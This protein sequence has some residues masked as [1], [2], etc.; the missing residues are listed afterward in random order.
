MR[1][2]GAGWPS[3]QQT[4]NRRSQARAADLISVAGHS[5]WAAPH[6]YCGSMSLE[7]NSPLR[8]RYPRAPRP[9]NSSV[10][11]SR[12]RQYSGL[13]P[14]TRLVRACRITQERSNA[15][16]AP[17]GVLVSNPYSPFVA[18]DNYGCRLP[19]FRYEVS[20]QID[21]IQTDHRPLPGCL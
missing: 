4:V 21:Q 13:C 14:E 8:Q 15:P 18:L 5:L 17:C 7:N 3:A 6:T 10:P 20:H 16:F 11:S 2:T 9:R 1:R 19:V 12:S